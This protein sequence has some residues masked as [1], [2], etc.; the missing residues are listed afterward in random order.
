MQCQVFYVKLYI[1]NGSQFE[2]LTVSEFS[3]EWDEIRTALSLKVSVI[4]FTLA[5]LL[6][7]TQ[8]PYKLICCWLPVHL[9]NERYNAIWWTLAKIEWKKTKDWV[10]LFATSTSEIEFVGYWVTNVV[11]RNRTLTDFYLLDRKLIPNTESA[12]S[13][14]IPLGFRSRS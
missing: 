12:V 2:L 6:L 11:M 4:R 13:K 5:F 9:W 10:K 14:P 7:V 3:T 1:Q 8:S